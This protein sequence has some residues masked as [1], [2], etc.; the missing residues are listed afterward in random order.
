MTRV[1]T[2]VLALVLAGCATSTRRSM[3]VAARDWITVLETAKSAAAQGRYDEA[4]RTLYDYAQRH[5]GAPE[6]RE[7]TY[8]RALFKLDPANR[9]SS[10]RGAE[11]HLDEYLADTTSTLHRD[12]AVI[13][14]RLAA[15]VDSLSQ[16]RA[17]VVTIS[18]SARAAEAAAAQQREDEL[19]KRVQQLKDQLDK[20]TAELERIKK[21]LTDKNP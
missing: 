5:A 8:W 11:E 10:T 3:P 15:Q 6:A 7:A 2:L 1:A 21:R 12:E 9:G 14:R 4:D 16:A 17:T 19:Q 18:D 20:T 13:L